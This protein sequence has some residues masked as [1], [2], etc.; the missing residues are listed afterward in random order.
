MICFHAI[1]N[2]WDIGGIQG[3]KAEI[4]SIVLGR[5]SPILEKIWKRVR[6]YHRQKGLEKGSLYNILRI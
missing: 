2:N 6:D 3:K 1:G 4:V 5:G